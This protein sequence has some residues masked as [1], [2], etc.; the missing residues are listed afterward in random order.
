MAHFKSASR[1]Q[2]LRTRPNLLLFTE[3]STHPL[4]KQVA[5]QEGLGWPR[6]GN[7]YIYMREIPLG[8]ICRFGFLYI[9]I[10]YI[11]NYN[12]LNN[13]N[14]SNNPNN[15]NNSNGGLYSIWRPGFE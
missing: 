9:Y 15:L 14:N 11:K 8:S 7:V 12:N 3:F 10:H 13:L 1:Y 5:N 2:S 4:R 6:G